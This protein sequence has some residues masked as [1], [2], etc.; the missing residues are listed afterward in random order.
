MK[1]TADPLIAATTKPE[2]TGKRKKANNGESNED[3][4]DIDIEDFDFDDD[5]GGDIDTTLFTVYEQ[6]ALRSHVA[7]MNQGN[8]LAD[9]VVN[10][11]VAQHETLFQTSDVDL[12]TT[13]SET[14]TLHQHG[15]TGYQGY[16]T[17]LSFI[18]GSLVGSISDSNDENENTNSTEDNAENSNGDNIHNSGQAINSTVQTFEQ[19]AS[20]SSTTLDEKQ[21][22]AFEVICC[23]FLLKLV[24]EGGGGGT[25]VGLYLDATMNSG[26][27]TRKG[28]IVKQLKA[29]GAQDQ[30]IMLL[31]GPAGCGKTMF[32]GNTIHSAAH[33][34]KKNITDT[35][36]KEWEGVRLLVID[37]VSFFK[38]SEV[39]KLDKQLKKLTERRDLPFGGVSIVFS[40]D[41]HQL[42][43]IC[44]MEEILYSAS[45]GATFWENSINCV[46]FLE[47]SH[48]FK[49]DPEY[50]EIL[51]R[52]RMGQDTREDRREM[53]SRQVYSRNTSILHIP[54]LIP[55]KC[56]HSILKKVSQVIQ[57]VVVTKLGDDAV[58]STEFK[59]Q[60][61]KLEPLLRVYPRAPFMCNTNDDL[62]HGRGNG[63]T[64]RSL[65]VTLK[66]GA[67]MTWKNWDGKKVNTV[68]VDDVKWIHFEHWPKPPR[69]ANRL[70][71][72]KPRS[73]S[74]KMQFPIS[75]F[76]DNLSLTVG[77]ISFKQFAV[78]SNIATTG[79]K[80]Q[81]MSKDT[82]IV[83]SW[84]Y[85]FPNWIYVVLSRVRTL[86]GLYL[87]KPLDLDKPFI[88]P[89]K[90]IQFERRMMFREKTFLDKRRREIEKC[91]MDP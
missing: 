39:R 64:C 22:I 75:Q 29:R 63:T 23:T 6:K 53:E 90:L 13:A 58:R 49:D 41:F 31:S 25:D 71:K 91:D 73:F 57:D 56:H 47:N 51:G 7:L 38:V 45:P 10:T 69:N 32:G 84:N 37:E 80:L 46:I 12:D 48:R 59:T 55:M 9:K 2:S 77:N 83:N 76:D 11:P 30:L 82:L 70:F 66:H 4:F 74:S 5:G 36:R 8:V 43:P 26:H 88:V 67:R 85:S 19:F 34:N 16:D 28:S 21:Y 79:H 62:D 14:S 60:G 78:N 50:G 24:Y 33:L 3:D 61:A 65:G 44:K 52:M 54:Q 1:R 18:E 27:A 42:Q 87:C 40:G 35:L 81:G 17:L 20:T 72:L 86:S 89:D 15:S 68:S